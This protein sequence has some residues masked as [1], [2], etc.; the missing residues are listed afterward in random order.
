MYANLQAQNAY[1]HST[2]ALR[3]SKETEYE[4]FTKITKD[5]VAAAQ[6]PD[7]FTAMLNALTRNERLWTILAKD[8]AS[9]DNLLPQATRAQIFYL[10]EF[11][12]HHSNLIRNGGG[13]I[14]SLIE[15]NRTIMRG[16]AQSSEGAA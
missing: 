5:L 8:V 11:T 13:Q 9:E 1:G 16:L 14:S 2:A 6:N 7:D 4:I 12:V 10:Y 15:V 3:G